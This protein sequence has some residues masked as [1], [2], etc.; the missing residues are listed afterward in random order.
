MPLGKSPHGPRKVGPSGIGPALNQA[1]I[2]RRV[3]VIGA[4]AG[5]V[6]AL[7]RLFAGLPARC[8]R[9]SA[10][11]CIGALCRSPV[12]VLEPGRDQAL[13]E[14]RIYLAP[15]DHH[16]KFHAGKVEVERGPKEHSTRPAIDPLF[17]SAAEAYG[18]CVVGVFLT[19]CGEDGVSGM[20]AR[21]K[22]SASCRTPR[23]PTCRPCR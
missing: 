19:G 15:A 23:R 11:S 21:P 14:G 6:V 8:R 17:R 3:I 20:I 2:K 1:G 16:L 10:W 12:S 22:G 4:S 9:W 5:G 7:Q 13:R 18:D